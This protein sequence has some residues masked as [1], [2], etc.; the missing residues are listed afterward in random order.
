MQGDEEKGYIVVLTGEGKGKTTAALGMALRATGHGLKVSMLQ[1]IKG[2]MHYGE[3]TAVK[4]LAPDLEIKPLGHGFVDVNPEKP[5]P[6]D[7]EAARKA[8]EVC[9][10]KIL[11]DRYAMVI[12]DEIN[13]AIA[14]GL[15]PV[16]EVVEVLVKRPE[17]LTVVL[18]GRGIHPSILAMADLVTEM[19]EL[20]HPYQKGKKAR[21]GIEY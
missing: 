4:K 17:R 13:D 5:D 7:V 15:L 20:K 10:K 21:K 9:K 16:E 12:L 18:T 8:W 19:I 14:Y 11:S 1:F 6:K 2:S 3:L